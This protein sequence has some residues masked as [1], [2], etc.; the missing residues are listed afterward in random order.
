ML[1]FC[2]SDL[3]LTVEAVLAR[4]DEQP[5]LCS[6]TDSDG[7]RWLIVESEHDDGDL[8]WI[9]APASERMVKLVEAGHADALDAVRHSQTGWVEVVRVVAGHSVPDW[10]VPCS[11][12]DRNN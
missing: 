8:A 6:A 5:S 12:L 9:C 1:R 3:E 2:G 11:A 4:R 10:R 7:R